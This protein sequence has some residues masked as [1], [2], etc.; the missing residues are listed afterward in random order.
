LRAYLNHDNTSNT[1]ILLNESLID[2]KIF[3]IYELAQEDKQI[4]LEKEGIP[5]GS[6]SVILHE[7]NTFENLKK[8]I[9][10]PEEIAEIIN[11]YLQKMNVKTLDN[12]EW[13]SLVKQVEE[14]YKKS[15][16]IEDIS[17]LCKVNPLTVLHILNNSS[18]IPEKK[19][20]RIAQEFVLDQART[21]LMA[22]DDGIVPLSQMSG[23][24]TVYERLID[25]LNEEHFSQKDIQFL[26]SL[27]GKRLD[28]YIE[29]EFFGD[30]CDILNKFPNLPMTPFI[31]HLSSGEAGGI[32]L[33]TIIY[34]W[35]R[36]KLLKI[37]SVYAQKRKTVLRTGLRSFQTAAQ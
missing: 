12:S 3:E 25:K 29:T 1:Q 5:A 7:G 30:E 11:E 4:V 31:W 27:L 17:L 21:I 32:D 24:K 35:S 37:K 33:Y 16:S 20:Q 28:K 19:S 2:E 8:V 9:S 23:E 22:D 18:V 36:D 34:K 10:S 26:E 6:L 13:Q 14:L 15:E